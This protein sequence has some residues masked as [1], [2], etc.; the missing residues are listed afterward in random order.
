MEITT[1]IEVRTAELAAV[2]GITARRVRQLVEDGILQN[3]SA[4]KFL[5]C[6]AVQLYMNYRFGSHSAE[7][8][9]IDRAKRRADSQIKTAKATIAK[10]EAEELEGKMHRSEDVAAMTEDL[11]YT[12]RGALIALPGRLAVDVATVTSAAEVA[13]II[14]REVY[15]VMR[16]LAGYQYDPAK[17]EERVRNRLSWEASDYAETGE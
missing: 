6:D 4:G 3:S 8:L 15:A 9:Q 10:L 2:L 5:L 11:I 16:E 13:E 1:T 17:Y 7:D 14:R 12:I